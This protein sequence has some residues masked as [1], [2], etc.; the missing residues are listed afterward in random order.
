M[1]ALLRNEVLHKL[2]NVDNL[3]LRRCA[4]YKTIRQA[5]ESPAR[6]IPILAL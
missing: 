4:A 6:V 2:Y 3:K 1:A 5:G